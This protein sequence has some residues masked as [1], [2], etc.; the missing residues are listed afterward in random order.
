[1]AVEIRELVIRTD[2]R[3]GPPKQHAE[4]STKALRDLRK[5]L[6]E[7]CRLMFNET[8]KRKISRR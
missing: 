4:L 7:E 5:Q 3:T 2:I 8:A 6:L 1:M